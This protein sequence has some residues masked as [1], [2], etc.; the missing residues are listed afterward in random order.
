[1]IGIGTAKCS[2]SE[3]FSN[4]L[5]GKN[6]QSTATRQNDALHLNTCLAHLLQQASDV[7]EQPMLE[8]EL[9]LGS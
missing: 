8:L 6:V 5:V 1:M 7:K 4:Q 3:I 2:M 9:D